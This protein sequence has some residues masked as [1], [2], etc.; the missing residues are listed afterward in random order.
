MQLIAA[1]DKIREARKRFVAIIESL[2]DADRLVEDEA[3][4]LHLEEN[5]P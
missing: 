2:D 1:Q 3:N 5:G 4:S